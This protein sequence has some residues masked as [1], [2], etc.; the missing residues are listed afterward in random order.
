MRWRVDHQI[1]SRGAP[2]AV[3]CPPTAAGYRPMAVGHPPNAVDS[4]PNTVDAA[5][6]ET[7]DTQGRGGGR[8]WGIT[9]SEKLVWTEGGEGLGGVGQGTLCICFPLFSHVS[10]WNMGPGLGATF[11]PTPFPAAGSPRH[12]G[13]LRELDFFLLRTA[14]WD[15]PKGPPTANCQPPPASSCQPPV[16]NRQPPTATNRHTPIA[17]NHG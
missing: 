7:T 4:P 3:G 13:V 15:R 16:A 14:L 1:A 2:T 8:S 9:S 12:R 5:N 10:H 11:T 17:T 6:P